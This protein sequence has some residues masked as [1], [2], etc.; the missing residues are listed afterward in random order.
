MEWTTVRLSGIGAAFDDEW[1][2]LCDRHDQYHSP[3]LAPAF[4][5]I[6]AAAGYDVFVTRV[7]EGARS[8]FFPFQYTSRMLGRAEKVGGVL[9]DLFGAIASPDLVIDADALLAAANIHY[10]YFDHL[11][12]EQ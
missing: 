7:A 6:A 3:F 4:S 9:S 1:R 12:E 10:L 8:A 2:A 11:A 5:L